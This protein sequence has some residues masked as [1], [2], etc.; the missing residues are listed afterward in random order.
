MPVK[1]T[2][3]IPLVHVIVPE[4]MA[5][6]AVKV[7]V[8]IISAVQAAPL[9]PMTLAIA[10]IGLPGISWRVTGSICALSEYTG[11]PLASV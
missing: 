7:D 5:W 1:L 8:A 6:K 10:S 2:V 11:S 4:A 3:P 9:V